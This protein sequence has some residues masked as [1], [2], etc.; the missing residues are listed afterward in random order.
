MG[1]KHDGVGDTRLYGTKV[2]AIR[3][4]NRE[5]STVSRHAYLEQVSN[6]C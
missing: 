5:P 3:Q 6:A 4:K 2:M 1:H